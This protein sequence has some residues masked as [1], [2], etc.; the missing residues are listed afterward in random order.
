MAVCTG[1]RCEASEL[2]HDGNG[3]LT[4]GS[5]GGDGSE[6]VGSNAG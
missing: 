4:S 3:L 6:W 1:C 2:A 5:T